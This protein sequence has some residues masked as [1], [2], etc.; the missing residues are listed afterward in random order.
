[1]ANDFFY[2]EQ[3]RRYEL[4]FNRIF[5][6]FKWKTG[7]TA[8]GFEEL[9]TVPCLPAN[10]SRQVEA[11]LR[12]GKENAVNTV[13][14]FAT[15]IGGVKLVPERRQD[16][17]FVRSLNV[18]ER[19]LD[20]KSGKYGVSLGNQYTLES[21][22]P[23]PYDFVMKCDLIT[24]NQSQKRQLME[25]IMILFNPMIDLQTSDNPLDWT[26]LGVVELTDIDWTSLSMPSADEELDVT[27]MTFNVRAWLSPPSKLKRQ[28]VIQ[29]IITNIG[30]L[31]NI[32]EGWQPDGSY[33]EV[34]ST[35]SQIVT[36]PGDLRIN[37]ESAGTQNIYKVTLLES[38]QLDRA[39]NKFNWASLFDEYGTYDVSSSQLLVLDSYEGLDNGDIRAAGTISLTDDPMV[40]NWSVN[41]S[42][43]PPLNSRIPNVIDVIDP[44]ISYP[45]VQGFKAP[46]PGDRYI[47]MAPL[48]QGGKIWGD[49]LYSGQPI[50]YE[51]AA[52]GGDVIE[53]DGSNWS[54]ILDVEKDI[55][56]EVW[57]FNETTADYIH[58]INGEWIMTIEGD[59]NPGNWRLRL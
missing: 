46:Q 19:L 9:R 28:T 11:I 43:L 10:G 48:Y 38:T 32:E 39:G 24:S 5:S 34:G 50:E 21:Y 3:I 8:S 27:S 56:T 49:I 51:I 26:G 40:L 36:T 30:T 44:N 17:D 45:G 35:M 2:Y 7:I 52:T 57:S 58:F 1:M 53:Y 31:D 13:P 29:E 59:Y 6:T 4:Q 15:Y 16:P 18:S 33:Y 14:Q 22:M 47:V 54:V 12:K 20:D 42:S 25:Q 37:I 41:P 55:S 23:V